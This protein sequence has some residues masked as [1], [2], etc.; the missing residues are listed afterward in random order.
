MYANGYVR[1][2]RGRQRSGGHVGEAVRIAI[3]RGAVFNDFDDT[4]KPLADGI[5]QVSVGEGAVLSEV[6]SRRTG[7]SARRRGP[8]EV[9]PA[10]RSMPRAGV[11]GTNYA[12]HR[13]NAR[14]GDVFAF[15]G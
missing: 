14:W 5:G 13:A 8:G 2:Y 6:I 9:V 4:V 15:V 7:L 10:T 1:E 3:S 12:T 11:G